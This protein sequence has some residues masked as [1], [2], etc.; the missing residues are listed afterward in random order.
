MSGDGVARGRLTEEQKAWRKNHPHGFVAKPQSLPNGIFNLM[1]WICS[2]P[3]Y[4]P[5]TLFAAI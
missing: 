5:L 2:I 3:G 1:I 4:Y